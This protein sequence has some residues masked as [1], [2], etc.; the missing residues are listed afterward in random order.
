MEVNLGSMWYRPPEVILGAVCNYGVDIWQAATVLYECFTGDVMFPGKSQNDQLYLYQRVKGRFPSKMI[1]K[2]AEMLEKMG[3]GPPY[4]NS[5]QR[6]L[7]AVKDKSSGKDLVRPWLVGDKP[8]VDLTTMV[9]TPQLS[10]T[11]TE[12]EQY[13]AKQLV[14][15]LHSCLLLNPEVRM[16]AEQAMKHRFVLAEK[17]GK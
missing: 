4:F 10:E 17:N 12:V 5:E 7:H 6:F 14:D 16:S 13:W 1:K 15:L 9:V 11:W 3:H 8:E 2:S